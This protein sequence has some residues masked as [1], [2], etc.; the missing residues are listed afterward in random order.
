[1]GA[2]ASSSL[3]GKHVVI[4]G[5]SFGAKNAAHELEKRGARVTLVAPGERLFVIFGA[6]RAAAVAGYEDALLIPWKFT[7][8]DSAHVRALATGVDDDRE[9]PRATSS[10]AP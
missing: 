6:V 9:R 3:A 7:R 1:M 2:S 8:A 5:G 10:R 4:V